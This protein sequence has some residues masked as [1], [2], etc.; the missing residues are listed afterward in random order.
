MLSDRDAEVVGSVAEVVGV[1]IPMAKKENKRKRQQ[2]QPLKE[3][4]EEEDDVVG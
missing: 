3:A 1:V 4:E 2:Q